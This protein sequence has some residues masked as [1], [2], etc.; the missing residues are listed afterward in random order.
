MRKSNEQLARTIA[1]MTDIFEALPT[2]DGNRPKWFISFGALLYLIRDLP[3]GIPFEQDIDISMIY[4]VADREDIINSFGEY[5]Y[6]LDSEVLDNWQHKPLKMAFSP[7]GGADKGSYC[8]DIFFWVIDKAGVAWHT[9]D[10]YNS[11]K[12]I[13]DEYVFKATPTSI[14]FK[15]EIISDSWEET[16]PNINL[17]L[18]YGSLLD[19]WYPPKGPGNES[20]WIKKSSNYGQSMTKNIVKITN[21]K[22]FIG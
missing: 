8:I 17:P 19:Y 12:T 9:Y 18:M 10:Q 2:M 3:L 7:N 14:L 16:A 6:K 21:C 4:G 22:E 11:G 20:G 15:P 1:S 5:G 13:L